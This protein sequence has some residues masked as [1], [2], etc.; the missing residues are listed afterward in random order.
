MKI[1]SEEFE[2]ALVYCLETKSKRKKADFS[3]GELDLLKMM[4]KAMPEKNVRHLNHNKV[5]EE[6]ET[7]S[8]EDVAEKFMMRAFLDKLCRLNNNKD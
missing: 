5:K 4:V 3:S 2:R 6:C 1:S 7:V 8:V